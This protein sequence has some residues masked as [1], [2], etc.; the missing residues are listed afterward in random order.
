MSKYNITPKSTFMKDLL[1]DPN[2]DDNFHQISFAD[3]YVFNTKLFRTEEWIQWNKEL[4]DSGGFYKYR[5]GD[6]ELNYLFFLIHHD[7]VVHDFKTV[8]EGY[9]DQG[10]YR[11][12]QNHAPSI[13]N[14][15]L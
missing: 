13:K 4:N 8:D 10:G 1:V 12:I 6:H 15:N 2:A 3:S 9:H 5:W 11:H 14:I 7:Y